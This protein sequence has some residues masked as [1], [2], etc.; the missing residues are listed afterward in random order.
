MEHFS[1][2]DP[3]VLFNS[4]L[5][6]KY[7]P[8]HHTLLIVPFYC[9][10]LMVINSHPLSIVLQNWVSGIPHLETA[11]QSSP[12]PHCSFPLFYKCRQDNDTPSYCSTNEENMMT[13][14]PIV[15]PQM[16]R[17]DFYCDP[18][19]ETV[20]LI[21]TQPL[22]IVLQ[23]WKPR[24][25]IPPLFS[26]TWKPASYCS[27]KEG[28]CDRNRLTQ[29][30]ILSQP[31]LFFFLLFY[32]Y[33]NEQHTLLIVLYIGMSMSHCSLPIVLPIWYRTSHSLTFHFLFNRSSFYC[34]ILMETNSHVHSIVLH[35]KDTTHC[36][37]SR[38]AQV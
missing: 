13:Q 3:I 33:G 15:L 23:K 17:R 38:T 6:S 34:S 19:I 11:N 9:S 24:W 2:T 18:Y 14:S 32:P 7:G 22:P 8:G 25:L 30:V 37:G 10:T 26:Q 28:N 1:H 16:E 31:L 4:P 36:L 27:P 21:L 35:I 20:W 5:S 29:P 12:S